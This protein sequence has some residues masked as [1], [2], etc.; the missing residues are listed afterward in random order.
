MTPEKQNRRALRQD[1]QQKVIKGLT[2]KYG[3]AT[4]AQIRA[5]AK[6]MSQGRH[7]AMGVDWGK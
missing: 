4:P 5:M 2:R 1:L 3:S 6:Q 7:P